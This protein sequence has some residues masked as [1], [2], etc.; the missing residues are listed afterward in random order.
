MDDNNEKFDIDD[1]IGE[2]DN[3]DFDEN[4]FDPTKEAFFSD[5]MEFEEEIASE[6]YELVEH[7]LSLINSRYF[8]D[9][10]EVLRQA[11]GSYAQIKREAEIEAINQKIS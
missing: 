7:A 6:G 9:A 10:I 4:G 8:D 5:L 3:G 2:E 11:I 1:N